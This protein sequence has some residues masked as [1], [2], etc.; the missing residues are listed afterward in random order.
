MTGRCS[1]SSKLAGVRKRAVARYIVVTATPWFLV[2]TPIQYNQ[3]TKTL[4]DSYYSTSST[5][6]ALR[7]NKAQQ[8]ECCKKQEHSYIAAFFL[9]D[10]TPSE[11]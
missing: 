3:S 7:T 8:Q 9:V 5:C 2:L 1:H 10:M 11:L 4:Y 6:C